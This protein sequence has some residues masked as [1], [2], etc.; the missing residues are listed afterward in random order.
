MKKTILAIIL[1][2][3][4]L[5]S[6]AGEKKVADNRISVGDNRP[7]PLEI[8]VNKAGGETPVTIQGINRTK[9]VLTRMDV[10]LTFVDT[11]SDAACEVEIKLIGSKWADLGDSRRELMIPNSTDLYNIDI[12]ELNKA[13]CWE[14]VEQAWETVIIE[15]EI[16]ETGFYQPG[17]E[18]E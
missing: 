9:R 5:I 17:E 6:C 16:T 11:V 7:A 3:S 1:V 8:Y 10:A 2:S 14:T 13:E 4:M 15:G 18:D 12:V